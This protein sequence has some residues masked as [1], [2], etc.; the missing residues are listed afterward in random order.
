[1]SENREEQQRQVDPALAEELEAERELRAK[2][3]RWLGTL[4]AVLVVVAIGVALTRMRATTSHL[5]PE[6]YSPW[7]ALGIGATTI[8]WVLLIVLL[9]VIF[10]MGTT[11]LMMLLHW[12]VDKVKG[13]K[14]G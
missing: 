7:E 3:H 6:G 12:I 8:P 5:V 10:S 4:A 11:R 13:K 9:G 14:A 1:M 2:V